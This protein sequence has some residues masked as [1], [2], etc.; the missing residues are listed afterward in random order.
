M[1]VRLGLEPTE[2]ARRAVHSC[3][4][5]YLSTL[6]TLFCIFLI[7]YRG[8]DRMDVDALGRFN[9]SVDIRKGPLIAA[10]RPLARAI[11]WRT[12]QIWDE[13]LSSGPARPA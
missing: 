10:V 9:K 1:V 5:S 7:E 3:S 13:H 11:G 6:P 12:E 2:R 4:L 8:G